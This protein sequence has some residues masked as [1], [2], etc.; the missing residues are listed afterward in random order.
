MYPLCVYIFIFLYVSHWRTSPLC[1]LVGRD[2][3]VPHFH[4]FVSLTGIPALCAVFKGETCVSLIFTFLCLSPAYQPF[5]RSCRERRVCPSFCV[6]HRRTSPLCGLVGR[7]MCVPH[8]HI[9]LCLSP[10]YLPFVR[11][12]RERRVCPSFSHFCVS[13]Q[14]T[15]PLCGLVERDVCVPHFHIF[16]SLTGVPAFCAVL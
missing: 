3:C 15:S 7:D 6:S 13:H 12:C 4:I 10:A 5:V 11:S 9:F 16:V 14:R 1:G 8:Y 2:M